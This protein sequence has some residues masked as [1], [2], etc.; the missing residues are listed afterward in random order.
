MDCTL[1][2]LG[3]PVLI[4]IETPDVRGHTRGL[5]EIPLKSSIP[6]VPQIL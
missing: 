6:P 3:W 1:E 4:E 2:V 5:D